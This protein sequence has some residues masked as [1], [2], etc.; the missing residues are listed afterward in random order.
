MKKLTMFTYFDF[1]GFMKGKTLMCTGVTPWKDHETG[2]VL[3]TKVE[4]A[5]FKDKTNYGPSKDG[6]QVTNL[7]EKI[8]FKVSKQID[9]PTGVEVVPVNPFA[10]VYGEYNDKLSVT[11]DDV[12]VVTK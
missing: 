5:I 8:T 11:A 3:G 1:E 4:T 12:Q 7:L 9:V 2:S 10:K 6:S